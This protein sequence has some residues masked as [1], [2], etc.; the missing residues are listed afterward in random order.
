MTTQ[1]KLAEGDEKAPE[2]TDEL[3]TNCPVCDA[4]VDGFSARAPGRR[5]AEPCGHELGFRPASELMSNDNTDPNAGKRLITDGGHDPVDAIAGFIR[6]NVDPGDWCIYTAKRIAK[7]T[8]LSGAEAGYWCSRIVGSDPRFDP[9]DLDPDLVLERYT[10]NSCTVRWRVR[11]L[12]TARLV[13]DGGVRWGDLT[14][15]QQ[16]LLL[17]TIAFERVEDE[18]PIGLELKEILSA[19]YEQEVN[20]GRLY[21]NLDTLVE[22]GLMEKRQVDRRSNHYVPTSSG[23]DLVRRT[24]KDAVSRV[25]GGEV[26]GLAATDGGRDE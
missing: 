11:H 19:F 26:S 24:M 7:G 16:R 1:P 10:N 25:L 9:I 2:T 20:H 22:K 5:T 6:E 21:P 23:R 17:E 3:T 15:F 18:P 8:E 12:R 13:A 14:E 4:A